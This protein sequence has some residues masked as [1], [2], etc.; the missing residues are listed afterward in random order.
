MTLRFRL[1]LLCLL[2]VAP[3]AF[4]RVISYAPYSNRTS[5]TSYHLRSS[6]WF[7]LA[8][9]L[10]GET[11]FYRAQV[12]LYDAHGVEEPRVIYPNAIE[13]RQISWV[14]VNES[15]ILIATYDQTSVSYK[16][17]YVFSS[18]A[19]AT[20]KRLSDLDGQYTD[21]YPDA[22][23]GG[24]YSRGLKAPVSVGGFFP[25]VI[26]TNGGLYGIDATANVKPLLRADS[27]NSISLAGRDR[28]GT[29]FL[30]QSGN[31]L[32][33]VDKN[34]VATTLFE[35]TGSN[36]TGWITGNGSVY[37]QYYL[38]YN[39]FL[40]L[41]RNGQ[42]ELVGSPEGMTDT[43]P[44]PILPNPGPSLSFFAV[45]THDYNGAWMIQRATGRPT[46][47][48]RH[49]IA[50]GKETMWSDVSGPEVE[51][52]HTGAAGDTL[53]IQV[54]RPR[55]QAERWFI[56]PA[57]AIWRVGQPAPRGYDELFLNETF[58]KGFVH[59]DVDAVAGGAPFVFDSGTVSSGGIITSPAPPVGG[60]GGGG[61]VMQEWGVVRASLKQRLVLPGIA[62]QPGAFNSYWLTD[63]VI[64]NPLDTPQRVD[65]RYVAIGGEVAASAAKSTT[66]TLAAHEIRVVK[67]V[68]K[69]LFSVEQG[70]GTLYIDPEVA[71]SA[72][73]RTFTRAS[74]GGGSFGFGMPAIDFLNAASP[75]FPVTFAG[76][77]PGSEYRTNML[78]T[79]T[80]GRGTEAR[81]RAHGIS[82]KIGLDGV[83]LSAPVNGVLQMNGLAGMLGLSITEAGGLEVQPTRGTMIVS[84]VAMDNRTNDPTFFPPDLPAPVVRT[85]PAIGHING[86]HNSKF[87]SDLFLMNPTDS[88]RTVTLEAK[89]WDSNTNGKLVPFTLLPG[90]ARVIRDALPTLFGMTGIAR[91]RYNS[92]D[93]GGNGV[94][95]TSRTYNVDENGWTYGTL[96]PPLNSFQSAGPGEQLEILGIVGGDGF[97]TNVGLVELSPGYNGTNAEARIHIVD[98]QGKELDQ[99]TMQLATA[100]GTQIND[101]FAARGITAPAAAILYVEVT[102][103]LIGAYATLTDNVTNDSTYLGAN[104]SAQP[105]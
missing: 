81:I 96:I 100:G 33:L 98:D 1:L 91:L 50:S 9:A 8:E 20:W 79:D 105:N 63:L 21:G 28:D 55:A 52:L 101:I 78:L 45:P 77:F 35:I 92:G 22:D 46:T 95:V 25:F 26:A 103:G 5:F 19:G 72:T 2:A 39:R 57:L 53:L 42:K 80:S 17:I 36:A 97:R 49:T 7:A 66:A 24:A 67:D 41:Y 68:V 88:P 27:T 23:T 15:Q 6:R 84:V 3:A 29:R 86:A 4:A 32:R 37:V 56:D 82:G 60:G 61:D 65:F 47:L 69:A 48:L 62:R 58:T 44:S 40:Y 73:A 31:T 70:G 59:V 90:E 104:L 10:P 51:A 11:P 43:S 71:V 76:A 64:H 87:R 12:V 38:N 93:G 89:L 102:K 54:H 75:R 85:I 34:G 74:A 94:R 83:A 16:P 14:A 18:D 99:F 30:V 13:T